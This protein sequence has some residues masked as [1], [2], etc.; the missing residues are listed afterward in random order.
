[1]Q[2]ALGMKLLLVYHAVKIRCKLLRK[3]L[4]KPVGGTA[5][6]SSAGMAA[7]DS[8]A[9]CNVDDARVTDKQPPRSELTDPLTIRHVAELFLT[10]QHIRKLGMPSL[11]QPVIQVAT[12]GGS[13]AKEGSKDKKSSK[14]KA[15][16]TDQENKKDSKAVSLSPLLVPIPWSSKRGTTTLAAA[17]AV[18]QSLGFESMA[19]QLAVEACQQWDADSTQQNHSCSANTH[20]KASSSDAHSRPKTGADVT[21]DTAFEMLLAAAVSVK[22]KPMAG[23]PKDLSPIRLQLRHMGHLLERPSAGP[24]DPRIQ[25]FIPDP[26]QKQLLDVVDAGMSTLKQHTHTHIDSV[27]VPACIGRQHAG[28]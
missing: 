21:A 3:Q 2:V 6:A 20:K 10:M 27:P 14:G 16:G 4:P 9:G 1:M 19:H 22:L 5:A 24:R 7:P 8:S 25:G 28:S 15:S 13:K 11:M 18:L 12:E 17:V 26:W 23:L